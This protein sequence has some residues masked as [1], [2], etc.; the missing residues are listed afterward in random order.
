MNRLFASRFLFCI[1]LLL[2]CSLRAD[3]WDSLI[4]KWTT[5]KTNDD[6]AVYFQEIEVQKN[7][8]KF[9]IKLENGEVPLFASGDLKLEKLGPFQTVTF[10]NTKAG[11]SETDLQPVDDDRA[12]VYLL[13]ENQWI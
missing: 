2:S 13:K 8:Y 3:D 4:G 11:Q 7:K 9:R 1:L 10:F 5:K 6:G 12:F